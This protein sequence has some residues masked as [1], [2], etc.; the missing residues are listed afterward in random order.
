MIPSIEKNREKMVLCHIA[1]GSV[2]QSLGQAVRQMEVCKYYSSEIPLLHITVRISCTCAYE[3]RNK[4]PIKALF[5]I[6]K[7][8]RQLKYKNG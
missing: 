8:Y 3:N 4:K 2:K 7:I 6:M 1:S 5:V